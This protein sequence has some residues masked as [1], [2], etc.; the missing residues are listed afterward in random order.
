MED[1]LSLVMKDG[2]MCALGPYH[3]RNVGFTS[4]GLFGV[5]NLFFCFFQFCKSIAVRQC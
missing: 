1:R 5:L 3:W 4:N 2:F